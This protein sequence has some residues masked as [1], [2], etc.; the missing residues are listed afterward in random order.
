M[1]RQDPLTTFMTLKA[2]MD[3]MIEELK[4]LSDDHFEAHPEE[5]NWGDVGD[6]SHKLELMRRVLGEVD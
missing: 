3:T 6:L 2:E 5:L 4:R 1:A